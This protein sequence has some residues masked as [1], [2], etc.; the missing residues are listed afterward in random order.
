MILADSSALIAYYRVDGLPKAQAAVARAIA[1]DELAVN[2]I[3]QAEIVSHAA[4]RQEFRKLRA[5]FLAFHWLP[6]ERATFDRASELGFALRR[7]GVT[8]PSTDLI[9]A[10]CAMDA[11]ATLYHLDRHFEQVARHSELDAVDLGKLKG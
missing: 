7:A 1:A 11:G 4:T 2:G 5:D 8:V 6:L 9:I 10:A 3:V